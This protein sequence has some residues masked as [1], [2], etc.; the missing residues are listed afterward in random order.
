MP[1]IIAERH[2]YN[3]DLR[4][5][6]DTL[7]YKLTLNAIVERT[8]SGRPVSATERRAGRMP[9]TITGFIVAMARTGCYNHP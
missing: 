5:I 6:I 9:T 1:S 4:T 2:R 3:K 7:F 8:S